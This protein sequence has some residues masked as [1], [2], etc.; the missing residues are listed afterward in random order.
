MGEQLQFNF[1]REF[2]K[3]YI[4]PDYIKFY[5]IYQYDRI[6][7]KKLLRKEVAKLKPKNDDE[8]KNIQKGILIKCYIRDEKGNKKRDTD[9]KH[10]FRYATLEKIFE[11]IYLSCKQVGNYPGLLFYDDEMQ[12][13]I[14]NT[15]NLPVFERVKIHIRLLREIKVTESNS[16]DFYKRRKKTCKCGEKKRNT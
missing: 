11:I 14:K 5:T 15:W 16:Y 7:F 13:E 1:M 8:F 2:N 6:K 10:I 3:K 12:A 4:P 9:E